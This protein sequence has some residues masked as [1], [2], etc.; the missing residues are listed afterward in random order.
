LYILFFIIIILSSFGVLLSKNPIHSVFFLI[1]VFLHVSFLLLLLHVEFLAFLIF[2][3]YLGAIA[4]L[5]LFV[6]MMF[7]IHILETRDNIIRYIP[8]VISIFLILLEMSYI[9]D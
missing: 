7:N 4:V 9:T 5:F 3:V 6:I 1:I 2:I 8:L